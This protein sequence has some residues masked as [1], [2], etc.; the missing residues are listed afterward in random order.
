[1]IESILSEIFGN[2]GP[3]D[4]DLGSSNCEWR[5]LKNLFFFSRRMST[6]HS[7]DV[8]ADHRH[9]MNDEEKICNIEFDK[10]E[11][12]STRFS[13]FLKRV[14]FHVLF[15]AIMCTHGPSSLVLSKIQDSLLLKLNELTSDHLLLPYVRLI[16]FWAYQI[17]ISYR[18]KPIVELQQL[19]QICFTLLQNILGKLLASRT[20][21]A[22]AEDY[23]GP[24]LRLEVQDVAETIFS[25]PAVVSSLSCPL[26]CQG[27]LMN[28]AIDLNLESLIHL[29]GKNVN[30]FDRHIINLL[31]TFCEH[32]LTSCDG[33]DSTSREVVETFNVLMQ[34]LFS[35]FRDRFD[36]FIDTM[37]PMPLLPPF[38]ALHALNHF[39]SPCD[40]LELVTWIF[41]RVSVNSLVIQK[42]DTTQIHGLSFGF[43][44]A[45]I[46]LKDVTSYLQLSF[47]R[48]VPYSLFWEMDEKNVCN[49]VDEI[50]TKINAFAIHYKSE[51]SDTCLLEVVKAICAKKSVLC[52]YF[53]QIHLA[54]FRL[55]MIIPSEL[56]SYCIYKTN[57]AKARLLFTLTEASSFHL[58]IFGH[59]MLDIMNKHSCHMDIEMVDT[60]SFHFSD[61]EFLMLLPTSLS[62]LNSVIVKFE[63]KC[64]YNF[65]SISSVYSGIIFQGLRKWKRFVSKS[66]FY[67]EFG[68]LVPS[69]TQEFV[70]LVNDSLLGKTVNMLRH[71][72]AFSGDLVTAKK[73]LKVFNSIF[74]ASCSGDEV[75]E[76]EVDELDSYSSSQALNFSNKVVAKISF[77]RVLL[78]PEG[79]SI[80]SL[81]KEDE[82]STENSLARRSNKEESSRLQFLNILASIWQWIVKRFAFISDIHD[83]EMDNSRLFRYLEL[84][85][86]NSVLELST[87]MHDALVKL[88]SIPFLEQLMRLSLLY[89][90]EDPTTLNVLHNILHL[91]SDGKFAE[92]L[93]LQLLLA[94]SQFAPAIHST[95]RPSYS[96]ET[97]LRPM[98]S[99]LRSLVIPPSDQW[100]THSKQDSESTQIDLK[101]LVI[102]KLVHIL[103]LM[104]VRKGGCGKHDT[105]NFRELYSLLL[106]SYGA[107]ISETD[108]AILKTLNEIETVVGSDVENLVQMDFLWGSAILRIAKERL[109]EQESSSN[110]RN[111]AEVLKERCKN[112]FRENLP[113]DPKM[114]VS[115]VLYFPHDR[116]EFDEELY[117]KKYQV[118]DL[119]DLFKVNYNFNI[120]YDIDQKAY[121]YN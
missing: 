63:K 6:T 1:M 55:I 101:R 17:R 89:R 118:K 33:Q 43:G 3:L 75:L 64:W 114:C 56:V 11:A 49:I 108:S 68:D 44:I 98:S 23:K 45:V 37:D 92:D 78:F 90:F 22:T 70:D 5:P 60:L 121:F 87:E 19:S 74:P 105:I 61:E 30:T 51:F 100:G 102:V 48:R 119:D 15:P 9:L 40:L 83:K 50:Y 28:G 62:Y 82:N 53:N 96:I 73:R 46:A 20:H 99:M 81:P 93:Y 13:T 35:E 106:S 104:K 115:T 91:L 107:T 57:K 110:I 24:L 14:P 16:L 86:L 31:T 88:P 117:S 76:F 12:S 66:I 27:D 18:L 38:F 120:L 42:S 111:D 95:P 39:I 36:H 84:F 94:H 52:D 21:S 58:S 80:P 7:E 113:V 71:H 32:L 54:M 79:Y 41:K 85:I 47:P 77:C 67:E 72:F 65:K 97:F 29:S 116:T 8:F 10:I 103:V 109:L 4:V 112:Q 25:H 34:R 69:S 59:F 26:T 2:H